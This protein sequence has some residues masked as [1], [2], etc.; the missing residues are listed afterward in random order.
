MINFFY[1]AGLVFLDAME[2]YQ[3]KDID[4]LTK[5]VKSNNEKILVINGDKLGEKNEK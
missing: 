2:Y 5:T 1:I 4:Q 3:Q